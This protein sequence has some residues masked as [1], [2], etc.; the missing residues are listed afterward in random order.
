MKTILR[1]GFLGTTFIA[2]SLFLLSSVQAADF[3]FDK[4]HSQ[5]RFGWDYQ[6]L[7]DLTA[8]FSNFDGEIK[9]DPADIPA[10][11][12]RVTIDSNSIQTGNDEFNGH[13]MSDEFFDVSKHPTITFVS[14]EVLQTGPERCQNCRGSDDQGYNKVSDP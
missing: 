5:I 4:G 6:G 3:N 2:G 13:L 9:F 12:V 10:S 14:R 11:F 8:G 1:P 7:V